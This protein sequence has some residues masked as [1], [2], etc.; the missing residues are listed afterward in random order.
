MAHN[1]FI[2]FGATRTKSAISDKDSLTDIRQGPSVPFKNGCFEISIKEL[3]DNFLNL[4]NSYAQNYDI[5]NILLSCQMHGFALQD[6][7][8]NFITDYISWQDE[9]SFLDYKG[10]SSFSIFKQSFPHYKELSGMRLRGCFPAVKILDFLRKNKYSQVKMLS[11]A[12]IFP[13]LGA[14]TNKVHLT[15]AQASG[16]FDFDKKEFSKEIIEFIKQETGCLITFNEPTEKLE[17]SAVLK[18]NGKNIDLLCGVGDHQASVLGALGPNVKEI[19]LNIGTGSQITQVEIHKS[20]NLENRFFFDGKI[21]NTIT[22]IPAGRVIAKYMDFLNENSKINY[23]D[24]LEKLSLQEIKDADLKFN[25]A[26]FQDGFG[27]NEETFG[28]ISNISTVNLSKKNFLAS[29]MKNFIYQYINLMKDFD[30]ER[31][32]IISGG[33]LAKNNLLKQ[34]LG[35]EINRKVSFSQ[36][37]EEALQGLNYLSRRFYE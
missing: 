37:E 21:L 23:W 29:L 35:E 33:K 17:N 24:V 2:D 12:E 14:P 16:C 25:L 26:L 27:F 18:V 9:S 1:L 11:L 32:I 20:K 13:L 36:I 30:N 3:S 8:N 6:E 5:K 22:H 7:K 10:K 15:M 31:D 19:S 4:V 28:S 34:F